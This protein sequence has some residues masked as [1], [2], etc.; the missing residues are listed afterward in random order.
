[1]LMPKADMSCP[2]YF[3]GQVI[4]LG[5]I[6]RERTVKVEGKLVN[7]GDHTK[8]F[9][10]LAEKL[11]FKPRLQLMNFIQERKSFTKFIKDVSTL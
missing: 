3:S 10:Y 4:S 7:A 9:L 8:L 5:Y 1:M 2:G 11:K 6:K